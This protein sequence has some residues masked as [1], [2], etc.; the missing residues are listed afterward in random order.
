MSTSQFKLTHYPILHK[1]QCL[2]AVA[3][4]FHKVGNTRPRLHVEQA[5]DK[6]VRSLPMLVHLA[7]EAVG[8][9]ELVRPVHSPLAEG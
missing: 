9:C 4:V 3:R 2:V 5:L 6:G 7:E 8:S 1:Y